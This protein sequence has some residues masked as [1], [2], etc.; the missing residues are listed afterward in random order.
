MTFESRLESREPARQESQEVP[1]RAGGSRC[2]GGPDTG[3][4]VVEWNG[5]KILERQ[6]ETRPELG[7]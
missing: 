6:A 1:S 2:K 7:S 3:E 4:K 5:R